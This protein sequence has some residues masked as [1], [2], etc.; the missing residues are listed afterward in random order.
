M[1]VERFVGVTDG[2]CSNLIVNIISDDKHRHGTA[3]P[4][5]WLIYIE[6]E[7]KYRTDFFSDDKGELAMYIERLFVDVLIVGGFCGELDALSYL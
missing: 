2:L 4:C 5:A 6:I 7:R 3:P 1:L